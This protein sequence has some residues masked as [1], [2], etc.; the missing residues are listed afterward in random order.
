MFK[1]VAGL[2]V[3]MLLGS[4]P[5]MA[6][7]TAATTI[8]LQDMHCEGC[9]KKVGGKLTAVSGVAK[10][11]YDVEQKIMVVT[12]KDN[13]VLSPKA[14]WQAV[15]KAGKVPTKLEGPSGTFTEKPKS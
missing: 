6:A 15:E 5:L 12:P 2:I 13:V 4:Q 11:E 1:H 14:L 8:T 7:E 10:V 9:A 3:V